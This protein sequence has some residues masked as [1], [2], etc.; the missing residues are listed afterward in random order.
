MCPV[1]LILALAL[2]ALALALAPVTAGADTPPPP[3][4]QSDTATATG[5]SQTAPPGLGAVTDIDINAY[6]GPS[7]ENPGGSVYFDVWINRITH[8]EPFPLNISGPVTCL[9]VR[10]NTAL[11]NF[12]SNFG[13][14]TVELVDNGGGGSDGFR[15][16]S[17]NTTDDCSSFPGETFE[18]SYD[19]SLG[20]GRAVVVDA[21]PLPTVPTTTAQCRNGG[22]QQFGFKNQGHCLVFVVFTKICDAFERRGHH[23]KFCPPTPPDP[24]R[25]D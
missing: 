18:F 9:N 2:I 19:H 15:F 22:W 8:L 5:A 3:A 10:G 11:V 17:G 24:L 16:G 4:P 25:P 21:Q 7:G 13:L 14:V 20:A 23:L 6:S 1:K 12:E